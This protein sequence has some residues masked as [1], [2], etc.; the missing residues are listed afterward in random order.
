[1]LKRNILYTAITRAKAK[2]YLVGE[3]GAVCQAI[4]TDDGGT[5]KTMLG[6]RIEKFYWQYKKER[7]EKTEQLKLAV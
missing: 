6:K 5:R 7:S 2:V 3:W 1:M 4:H